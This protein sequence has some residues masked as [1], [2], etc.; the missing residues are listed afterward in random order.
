M[1]KAKARSATVRDVSAVWLEALDCGTT[2]LTVRT[3][4]IVRYTILHNCT[5]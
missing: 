4:H 3:T 5:L 2:H 1:Q